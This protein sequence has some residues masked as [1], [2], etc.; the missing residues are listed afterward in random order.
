[1]KNN[2]QLALHGMVTMYSNVLSDIRIAQE[3]GYAGVEIH[4]EKL[5][6]FLR[7]GGNANILVSHLNKHRMRV[8]AIDIIR[9]LECTQQSKLTMLLR[10][11]EELSKLANDIG[12][13]VIQLNAFIETNALTTRESIRIVARNIKKVAR[14]G[15][16]YGVSFQYEGCAWTPI[17]RLDDQIALVEEVAEENVGLVIDFWHLWASR[18]GTPD[19]VA[20]LDSRYIF[21]VHCCGGTRPPLAENS[22]NSASDTYVED[23]GTPSAAPLWQPETVYRKYYPLDDPGESEGLPVREYVDAV[24]ATSY[25][26][27]V[28]G[29]FLNEWLW[30]QDTKECAERMYQDLVSL[31]R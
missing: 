22:N 9:D 8:N 14:I 27:W 12:A 4:T 19:D 23:A 13:G 18:S 25:Q 1:M 11:A 3:T 6:R 17:H 26:G 21:G 2:V 15:A 28:S 16:Q 30:E 7:A 5:W 31:F 24:L 10:E 20:V 29:E